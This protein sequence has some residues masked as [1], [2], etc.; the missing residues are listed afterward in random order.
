MNNGTDNR[1]SILVFGAIAMTMFLS[2]VAL[3]IDVGF[4]VVTKSELHNVADAGA[5]AGARQLGRIYECL[6]NP[7]NCAPPFN[8]SYQ[9]Q[10][11]YVLSAGDR[12][13]VQNAVTSVAAL[14]KAGSVPI[15]IAAA[16]I[17]IGQWNPA[18]KTLA[19]TTAQPHAVQVTARRD[20]TSNGPINTFFAG[21]M[22][23]QFRTLNVAN[24]ATAALTAVSQ[25]LPGELEAPIGISR[26]WFTGN[27]CDQNIQFYPTNSPTGCAGWDTFTDAPSNANRL[28]NMID[29]LAAGSYTTPGVTAGQTTFQFTG[30]NVAN[31]LNNFKNLWMAKRDPV[32]HE[33]QTFVV[34]YD[35]TDCS[36]PTGA[37]TIVGFA[38]AIITNVLAPPAGQVVVGRVECNLVEGGRG[39][40]GQY[41]TLGSI[42]GLVQ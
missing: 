20:G 39:G 21:I 1:G 36:S 4:G 18:T 28:R 35:K 41:G 33:W 26:A 24:Q 40:G 15:Q 30:G 23:A 16:D 38:T 42:P 5:L 29:G 27:F 7:P 11:T 31:A 32:T 34:V 13:L 22:G 17:H 37:I 10:Q 6:P 2:F 3:T 9:A 8:P 19:A 25:V 12:A 14:N